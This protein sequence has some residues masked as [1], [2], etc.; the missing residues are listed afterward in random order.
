MP[1]SGWDGCQGLWVQVVQG[2][3]NPRY[4]IATAINHPRF[5]HA[6]NTQKTRIKLRLKYKKIQEKA[7]IRGPFFLGNCVGSNGGGI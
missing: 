6:K 3:G 1:L 4:G 5:M 7:R 2:N